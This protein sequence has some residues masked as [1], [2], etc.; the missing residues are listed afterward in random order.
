MGG[1]SWWRLKKWR[2]HMPV[3]LT[4]APV[5]I[6]IGLLQLLG[7][8]SGPLS[9]RELALFQ[10]AL[11]PEPY[12]SGVLSLVAVLSIHVCVCLCGI[13]LAWS[14]LRR[15]R[16]TRPGL[17]WFGLLSA[18]MV[19]LL[20]VLLERWRHGNQAVLVVYQISYDFFDQLYRHTGAEKSLL[21]PRFADVDALGWA[22]V[23]PTL[24]G[25]VGVGV[26]A[27]AAAAELRALPAPPPLPDPP[28]EARLQTAQDRLKRLLYVLT[29]GLVTSTIAV[30][31]FF[32]LPSKL[33]ERSFDAGRPALT[34]SI[35]DMDPD[36]LAQA[37]ALAEAQGKVAKLQAAE[38]S[39][40]RARIDDFAGELSIFWG[41][42]FT[43]ILLAAG[44]VPLL[45]LQQKVR[46]YAE[47]ARDAAAL[48]A[49][50]KRLSDNG[51]LS[52]GMDQV[53][54]IGAVIAPLASGP[55]ASFV[56]LALG[57]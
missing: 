48:E 1:L 44:A 14:M 4:A 12:L 56:Q 38:L 8:V 23:I 47:N 20:L 17:A 40:L 36:A 37:A 32:H 57:H 2:W 9:A 54:L 35:R 29:I 19:G 50:Q 30:S 5:L 15:H 34:Y 3:L 42:I 51:L 25:I 7:P 55:I 11:T 18:L 49:A 33:A 31:L 43:L 10:R 28:Y 27:A 26:T 21:E 39:L 53:K 13:F 24:I 46:R 22:V 6:A 52:G 45:L 16:A 41:A